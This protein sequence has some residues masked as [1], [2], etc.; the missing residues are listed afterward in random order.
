LQLSYTCSAFS[1]LFRFKESM[2]RSR[3]DMLAIYIG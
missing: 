2:R 3:V 1:P